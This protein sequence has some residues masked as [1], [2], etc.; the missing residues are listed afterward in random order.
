MI[1]RPRVPELAP[2]RAGLRHRALA[3]AAQGEPHRAISEELGIPRRTISRWIADDRDTVDALRLENRRRAE[4]ILYDA[5][6][7]AADAL[8][9]GLQAERHG[10]PDFRER[11]MAASDILDRVGVEKQQETSQHIHQHLHAHQHGELDSEGQAALEVLSDL[12]REKA[13]GGKS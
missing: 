8:V 11:R 2:D 10:E 12:C 5:A 1:W 7:D 3:L 9:D 13:P 4:A 6:E